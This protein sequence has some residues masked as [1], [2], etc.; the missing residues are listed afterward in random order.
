MN[1][2]G[3]GRWGA[4]PSII[5]DD[6]YA[7]LQFAPA[8]RIGCNATYSWP[9][10]EGFA[11]LVRVRRRQDAGVAQIS[12]LFPGILAR[13]GKPRL[14]TIGLVKRAARDPVGFAVYAA[15]S[16]VV[17]ARRGGTDWVRGR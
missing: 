12:E 15:V 4:F 9:M 14:G 10:I 3:R 13:E 1:A 5:S 2:E 6:T 7:R 17:K 16:L 8:E 11:A